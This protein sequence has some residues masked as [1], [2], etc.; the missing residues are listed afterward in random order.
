MALADCN[1]TIGYIDDL[2]LTYSLDIALYEL[3]SLGSAFVAEL[4][5]WASCQ[6]TLDLNEGVSD[7]RIKSVTLLLGS[8][9]NSTIHITSSLNLNSTVIFSNNARLSYDN[10]SFKYDASG[11]VARNLYNLGHQRP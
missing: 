11:T 3:G 6:Y 5:K 4:R 10:Q 1:P 2:L 7:K 8:A 9:L